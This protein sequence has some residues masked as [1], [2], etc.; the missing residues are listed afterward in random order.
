LVFAS[1]RSQGAQTGANLLVTTDMDCNWK[2]DGQRM[3]PLKAHDSKV[4]P[5]APPIE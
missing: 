1:R 5:V 2:L 3:D 4:F